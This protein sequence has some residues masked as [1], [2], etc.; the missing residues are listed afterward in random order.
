MEKVLSNTHPLTRL[1]SPAVPLPPPG[2]ALR[3]PSQWEVVDLSTERS[4]REGECKTSFPPGRPSPHN[5]VALLRTYSS[6]SGSH[7]A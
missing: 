3:H 2:Q 4:R 6:P 7:G 5:H 1:S